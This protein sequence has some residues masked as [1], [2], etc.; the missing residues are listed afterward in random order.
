MARQLTFE[1][2]GKMAL[3]RESF[4]VTPANALAIARI[5]G[6]RDWPDNRMVLC[7]PAGSG[8][9][10]LAHVFAAQSGARI[11]DAATLAGADVAAL[12]ALGGLVV[13]NAH[14]IAADPAREA[15]MF[16]LYNLASDEGATLLLTATQPP[17]RWPIALPDLASR[18]ASVSVVALAA[19]DDA[20]LAALLV[21]LFDDRQI[22]VGAGL[23]PYLVARMERSASAAQ[24]LVAALDRAAL[25][26]KRPLTRQLAAQVLDKHAVCGSYQV[27]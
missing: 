11:I 3:G 7:G 4:F 23:I 1:L 22:A 26:A 16:H 13:E 10:H 24:A 19:P 8:K 25:E 2:P 9:S 14:L 6:W 5:E 17:A 15:A 27:P 21:K 12:V 18:L 20:L